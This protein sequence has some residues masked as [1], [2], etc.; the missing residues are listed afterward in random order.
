MQDCVYSVDNLPWQL[1]A[2]RPNLSELNGA[3]DEI[4]EEYR[5]PEWLTETFPKKAPYFPQMGDELIYFMQ[6]HMLYVEAVMNRKLYTI[7]KRS[8]PWMR[9]TNKL[10]VRQKL[11]SLWN[12]QMNIIIYGTLKLFLFLF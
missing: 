7:D 10:R 3:A 9:T 4:P 6:G 8:L 5:P 2:P 1:R 11:W 12:V